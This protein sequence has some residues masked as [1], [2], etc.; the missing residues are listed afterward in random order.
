M[1]SCA[2]GT[3]G[4]NS[5]PSFH[6]PR[7]SA[8]L[9]KISVVIGS[10]ISSRIP[11]WPIAVEEDGP[12]PVEQSLAPTVVESNVPERTRRRGEY[13]ARVSGR[14]ITGCVFAPSPLKQQEQTKPEFLGGFTESSA[15]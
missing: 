14:E 6:Q 5:R 15:H 11:R 9:A 13:G 3:I 1:H 2:L 8:P 7:R 12:F 10:P 4:P